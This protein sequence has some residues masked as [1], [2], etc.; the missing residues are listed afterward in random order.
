MKRV[1]H[2]RRN[3]LANIPIKFHPVMTRKVTG[4]NVRT[5]RVK[6]QSGVMFKSKVSHYVEG[7]F[8]MSLPWEC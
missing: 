8:Q 6:N 7:S 3:G 4:N 2:V 1:R 5:G